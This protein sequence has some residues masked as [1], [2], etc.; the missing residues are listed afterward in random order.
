MRSSS[1]LVKL[2]DRAESI[3]GRLL[4]EAFELVAGV[5]EENLNAKEYSQPYQMM[6]YHV[7]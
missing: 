1:S 7:L 4:H 3:L 5:E 6:A 2:S